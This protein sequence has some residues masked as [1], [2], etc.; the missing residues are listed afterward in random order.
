MQAEEIDHQNHNIGG[1]QSDHVEDKNDKFFG[2][3]KTL[4]TL[5]TTNHPFLGTDEN[6]KLKT[7]NTNNDWRK[8][9]YFME[10]LREF[11]TDKSTPSSGTH[12]FLN[13]SVCCPSWLPLNLR[14]AR[15]LT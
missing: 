7:F 11:A 14:E 15:L 9:L 1:E 5:K 3:K 8:Y 6:G 4:E 13:T 10:I 12:L 2:R